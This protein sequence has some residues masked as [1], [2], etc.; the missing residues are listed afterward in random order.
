[1]SYSDYGDD[2]VDVQHVK[3]GEVEKMKEIITGMALMTHKCDRIYGEDRTTL[4]GSFHSERV[5]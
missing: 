3:G 5:L 4:M 2:D 1:V